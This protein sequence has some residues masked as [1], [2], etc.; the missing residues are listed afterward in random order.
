MPPACRLC[1]NAREN[2][3]YLAKEM[4]FGTRDEFEYFECSACGT[5]QIGDIPELA[6]YYPANYL[7]F[8][9]TVVM[10]ETLARRVAAR[11]AGTFFRTGR[12]LPG[13]LAL[14]LKPWIAD[15]YPRSMRFP[16]LKLDRGSRILDVGCGRGQLLQSLHHFGFRDLTGIDPFIDSDV[17]YPTGVRVLKRRPEDL[18]PAFDLIMMHHSL[19]HV[20]DP[21]ATLQALNRLLADD[22]T[23]LVRIPVAAD[24]WQTYRTDWVQMDPPRHLYLF[25]ERA[26]GSV[27]EAAGL[28]VAH[29]QYDSTEFQFWG[30]EQYRRG[31]PLVG[32]GPFRGFVPSVE[33]EPGQIERWREEAER[34]NAR[35]RGDQAC[36]YLKRS[37]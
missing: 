34:L 14:R 36:F 10:G 24:A 37:R 19:E 21:L 4:M 5:V 11:F 13:R 20:P 28:S 30:S 15:H 9:S 31:V 7:S 18:E 32:P 33:F 1:H 23:L 35:H 8:D 17:T 2:V 25:T 12:G 16:V 27:A 22:G 26:L 29:V 3:A 6:K